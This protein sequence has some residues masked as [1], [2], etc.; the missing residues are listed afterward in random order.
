M[1]R[2]RGRC[3]DG[4]M[5]DE[6]LRAAIV[7]LAPWHHDVEIRPGLSTWEAGA[8]TDR[9]H[10]LGNRVRV[11]VAGHFSPLLTA[12]FPQGLGG[13]SFL[14]CACNA[15]GYTFAA[16]D[17]GAGRCFGFDARQLWIDQARL[18]ASQRPGEDVSFERMTLAEL[19]GRGFEPFDITFFGGIFYH[20]SD[21]VAGLR[22]A[23]DLTRDLLIV[24][25][26]AFPGDGRSLRLNVE[27]TRELLSGI[28]GL[29]WLPTG[30]GVVREI[31]AWCGFPHSRLDY[32]IALPNGRDRLQIVAAREA[33]TLAAYDS[34]DP[35]SRP[36]WANRK[37][38]LLRRLL[39]RLRR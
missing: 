25:T 3:H 30:P 13:R 37:R 22:I 18:I 38:P 4:A 7:G 2:G 36:A 34:A 33:A 31:L 6:D 16:L 14:D 29:A 15:G 5:T 26:A 11:K 24:N 39:G 23:A 9:G 35:A 8:S 32:R 1:A 20:L 17:L 28:D 21:P 12:L 10:E 19:P 27:S